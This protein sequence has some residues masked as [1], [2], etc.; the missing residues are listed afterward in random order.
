MVGV[1]LCRLFSLNEEACN[2]VL[3]CYIGIGSKNSRQI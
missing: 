2:T 1:V 3:N